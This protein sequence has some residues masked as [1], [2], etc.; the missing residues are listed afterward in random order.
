[1]EEATDMRLRAAEAIEVLSRD[2]GRGPPAGK[3]GLADGEDVGGGRRRS[4]V[5][6]GDLGVGGESGD[7]GAVEA[8]AYG[9]IGREGETT[10][11]GNVEVE[12]AIA[13]EQ[14][15]RASNGRRRHRRPLALSHCRYRS[16]ETG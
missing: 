14:A 9:G 16:G 6:G 2:V 11:R 8:A 5:A 3:E 13:E 12:T 15:A 1:M 7:G 4:E 10:R